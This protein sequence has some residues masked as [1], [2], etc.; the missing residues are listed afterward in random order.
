MR[1]ISFLVLLG[2][3]LNGHAQTPKH[4]DVNKNRDGF[5]QVWDNI[6]MEW[7][8]VESFWQRYAD[9]NGGFSWGR[10]QT[11]P[12]YEKVNEFDTL[13]IE[14]RQGPCLMEFYHSRWRRA[15]DV[16]RWNKAI[17]QFGG[18]PYVFD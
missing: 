6:S 8:E 15:N 11:Y 12:K 13:V 9:R 18:C 14:L 7:T 17:N 10:R 5:T 3:L 4:G 2:L 1:M 16:R